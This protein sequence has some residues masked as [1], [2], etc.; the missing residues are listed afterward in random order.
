[1]SYQFVTV[2]D[3]EPF[4]C[5]VPFPGRWIVLVLRVSCEVV[6]FWCVVEIEWCL[7]LLLIVRSY[8]VIA[9]NSRYESS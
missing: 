8:L 3:F 1:M 6:R 4:Q 2:F 9:R 5:Y 7:S